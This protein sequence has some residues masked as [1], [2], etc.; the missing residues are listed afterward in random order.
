MM[1][2][3]T[4]E[5]VPSEAKKA[6]RPVSVAANDRNEPSQAQTASLLCTLLR[7]PLCW[8]VWCINFY[9]Y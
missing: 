2:G 8:S 7:Y 5:L 1:M 4:I 6:S 9:I 3:A